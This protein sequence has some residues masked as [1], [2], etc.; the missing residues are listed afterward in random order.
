MATATKT[1]KYARKTGTDHKR[2]ELAELHTQLAAAVET[3]RSSEK[4]TRYLEFAASFHRYSFNNV[5][6]IMSQQPE[7]T[8]VA[9][10][11]AW[12]EKGRQVRKGEKSIRILGT[13]LVKTNDQNEDNP[14]RIFFPVSVFDISQ[15]DLIDGHEDHSTIA[16]NLEGPDK[17]GI[18]ARVTAHLATQNIPVSYSELS[19]GT[20]GH[21]QPATATEPTRIII[22]NRN[23][24]AQKAKTL[25]HEAAHIALDH[26]NDYTE[27]LT[28]RGRYEVEAETTAAITAAA[29]G[30]NTAPY[31]VGYIAQWSHNA[32]H[33]AIKDTAQRALATA[34]QLLTT[35]ETT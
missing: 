30:L 2:A 33:D 34:H 1:R 4:W 8:H 18:I 28:H 19:P 20:N 7:A 16:H 35:L 22:E 26:L 9:G 27:Y 11:R 24:P 15:T 31:S 14:R 32:D 29:L 5:M 13:R 23:S 10:F 21:T 25:L 17:H 12:Q 6:L 3:L